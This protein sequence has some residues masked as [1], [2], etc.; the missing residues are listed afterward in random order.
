VARPDHLGEDRAGEMRLAGARPTQEQ[1]AAAAPAHRREVR[2]IGTA[3]GERVALARA[4]DSEVVEPSPAIA[5]GDATA[6]DRPLEC[7]LGRRAP[8]GGEPRR[9]LPAE[10][11]EIL[12]PQGCA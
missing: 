12:S 9:L 2:R 8:L 1:Q 5:R 3:H 11:R 10:L 4:V 6:P 7:A